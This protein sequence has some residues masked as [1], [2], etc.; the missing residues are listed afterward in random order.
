MNPV[1]STPLP[2]RRVVVVR[3]IL[4]LQSA[5]HIGIFFG[6]ILDRRHREQFR[7]AARRR[8]HCP[9]RAPSRSP[10]RQARVERSPR[11]FAR[12]QRRRPDV[13]RPER[14]LSRRGPRLAELRERD[15]QH[16]LHHL[17]DDS[18]GGTSRL[19][20]WWAVASLPSIRAAPATGQSFRPA[21]SLR[22]K[23]H[24][25]VLDRCISSTQPENQVESQRRI[26]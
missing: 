22:I 25:H 10:R 23:V 21:A 16:I 3:G 1:S 15:P 17:A 20:F 26:A 9:L 24:Q 5:L 13:G 2:C 8:V 12:C 7:D 19:R 14:Q 11:R 4:P 18:T 6:A